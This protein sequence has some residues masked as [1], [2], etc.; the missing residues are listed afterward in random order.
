MTRTT[1][2]VPPRAPLAPALPPACLLP[3]A[4]PSLPLPLAASL[5]PHLSLAYTFHAPPRVYRRADLGHVPVATSA[6]S[7]AN[8]ANRVYYASRPLRAAGI[9][10]LDALRTEAR[11]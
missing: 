6:L 1:P 11:L 4:P 2:P 7:A 8:A 5:P 9:A 3:S 10:V